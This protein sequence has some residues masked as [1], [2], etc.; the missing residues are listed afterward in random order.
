MHR[1]PTRLQPA[2]GGDL[3]ARDHAGH[4][5]GRLEADPIDIATKF[6]GR[7]FQLKVDEGDMVSAGQ[8]V[9]VMDTRDLAA[10]LAR[11]VRMVT[12]FL[13]CVQRYS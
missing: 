2:E 13:H 8:V 1:A 9:A 3:A 7:I 11:S 12:R 5:L 10:S 4:G 6:A